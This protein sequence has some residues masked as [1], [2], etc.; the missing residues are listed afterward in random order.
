MNHLKKLTTEALE[1]TKLSKVLAVFTKR[2][3]DDIKSIVKSIIDNAS[4]ATT[5][6]DAIPSKA[7]YNGTSVGPASKAAKSISITSNS[8]ADDNKS[9]QMNRNVYI[10]GKQ[11]PPVKLTSKASDAKP[12][13]ESS[14]ADSIA[15]LKR[16]RSG[17]EILNV[18]APKRQAISTT[19]APSKQTS[20]AMSNTVKKPISTIGSKSSANVTPTATV[21]KSKLGSTQGAKTSNFF[22]NMQSTVKKAQNVNAEPAPTPIALG[23]KI[24]PSAPSRTGFSL[25]GIIEGLMNP[26]ATDQ[27]TKSDEQKLEETEEEKAKRLRKESRRKLRVSWKAD[28]ELVAVREFVHDPEEDTGH[29]A[30]SVRDAGDILNEGKAFKEGL[31]HQDP[32]FDEGLDE[33]EQND[34][35][36]EELLGTQTFKISEIDAS[37][38]NGSEVDKNYVKFLGPKVPES[39]ERDRQQAREM[40]TLMA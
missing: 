2:G 1:V 40:N 11:N 28:H 22:S 4:G 39:P 14:N 5:N 17:A 21:A 27:K 6:N 29:D 12:K 30:R 19:A 10:D 8:Q 23:N 38:L 13:P 25:G 3:N 18:S 33:D 31:K 7:A 24:G 36:L 9:I 37:D 20:I 32:F 16:A 35:S 15:G 34:P 26:K